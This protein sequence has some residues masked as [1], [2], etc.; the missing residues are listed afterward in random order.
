MP[1]CTPSSAD[2]LKLSGQSCCCLDAEALQGLSGQGLTESLGMTASHASDVVCHFCGAHHLGAQLL[3][4][5]SLLLDSLAP[6]TEARVPRSATWGSH[7]VSLRARALCSL[8]P[9]LG[10][11]AP[12][13][14]LLCKPCPTW[15]FQTAVIT[16]VHLR[17]DLDPFCILGVLGIPGW[18]PAGETSSTMMKETQRLNSYCPSPTGGRGCFTGP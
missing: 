8:A 9:A 15:A 3:T 13:L 4:M 17:A 5:S 14:G 11:S 10:N 6:A 16:E 2:G 7:C 12:S 18:F 1:S